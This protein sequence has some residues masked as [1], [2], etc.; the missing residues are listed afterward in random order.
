[1]EIQ[2]DPYLWCKPS[3][4]LPP[5][6]LGRL[7]EIELERQCKILLEKGVIQPSK[8][9]HYSHAFLVPK[10]NGDWRF[11]LDF[12][13]LNR[14]TTNVERWPI[15]NIGMLLRN[16]GDRRPKFFVVMDLTSGFF[17][18][19]IGVAS[20]HL[21]AFITSGGM[22]EWTRVAMGTM[23]APPY[24]QR[25]IATEVLGGLLHTICELYIDDILVFGSTI[26]EILVNTEKVLQRLLDCG[27][28]VNPDKCTFGLSEIEYVGH[29][30]NSEGLHF[31]RDKLDSVTNFGLPRTQKELKG[32]LGL[33]NYFRD[34]MRDASGL[35]AP[36]HE[37]VRDYHPAREVKWGETTLHSFEEVK[38]AIDE[39]P[40]LHFLDDENEIVL[41]TDACNTGMG[42]YLFQRRGNDEVPVA[43]ISKAFDERLKKWCTFQQ[44]GFAI[45]Y[46][47][48][49]W[50][51]LLLDRTFVLMT[52]HANLTYLK[53]S[54]DPK[55][56]RWMVSI[57][58]FDF[59]VRHIKGKD[60]VVADAFS[61]LCVLNGGTSTRK[62][63]GQK[64][65]QDTPAGEEGSRRSLRLGLKKQARET[66]LS[67][68]ERA[69]ATGSE[70]DTIVIPVAPGG[71][72]GNS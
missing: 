55:V 70:I 11:V 30:I 13:G 40:M 66:S 36:L 5:R 15:P 20:R 24:F 42:A 52:D 33:V 2:V 59:T 46:A 38:K 7:R 56:L 26:E 72:G 41:Q 60:N 68:H 25:V 12:Q 69:E 19:P 27:M 57:Q 51:H 44:E 53:G 47:M 21:T 63:S 58:E 34:H 9:G 6:K 3:N 10:H 1:M 35:M 18:A 45:Y 31:T 54:S 71:G 49:K 4:K 29:T 62:V 37:L 14:A 17:Q 67:E 39:C 48:K 43:F 23:S 28:T 50:R 16:V 22:Y 64:R 32:F 61:R 65:N 8:A